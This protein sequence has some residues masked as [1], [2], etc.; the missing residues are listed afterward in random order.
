MSQDMNGLADFLQTFEPP[1]K[2]LRNDALDIAYSNDGL[3][4]VGITV[5]YKEL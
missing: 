2:L 3:D 5:M 1:I 4:T